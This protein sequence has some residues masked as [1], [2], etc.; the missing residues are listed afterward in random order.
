MC[1][2][3]CNEISEAKYM[4]KL[5]LLS[6]L[7]FFVAI[8]A[9]DTITL[10]SGRKIE[11]SIIVKGN[12]IHLIGK[13]GTIIYNASDVI[14]EKSSVVKSSVIDVSEKNDISI[15]A[16]EHMVLVPCQITSR[17]G[18]I[19]IG[20]IYKK[21]ED[22]FLVDFDGIVKLD[23]FIYL[24]K[25]VLGGNNIKGDVISGEKCNIVLKSGRAFSGIVEEVDD[26]YFVS[27][28]IGTV[29]V[30]KKDLDHIEKTGYELN[31]KDEIEKLNE[32]AQK[33]A[34]ANLQS[35]GLSPAQEQLNAVKA[36]NN[37]RSSG[38]SIDKVILE[39]AQLMKNN[40][41]AAL[42]AFIKDQKSQFRME[43]MIKTIHEMR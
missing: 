2:V 11:G 7:I 30:E 23:P 38:Q 13:Y 18:R 16:E 43:N 34:N 8:N 20:N 36:N 41:D 17:S 35:K 26:V 14:V 6:S 39:G 42:K 19:I 12:E 3:F 5:L 15:K 10:K 32:N 4:K 21:G 31:L 37:V 27:S 29:K 33:P 24:K 9:D 22:S 1:N 28:V 40:S 25:E